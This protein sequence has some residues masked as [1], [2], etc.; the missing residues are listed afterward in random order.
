MLFRIAVS[1][2]SAYLSFVFFRGVVAGILFFRRQQS[3]PASNARFCKDPQFNFYRSSV[4]HTLAPSD[5]SVFCFCFSLNVSS[6][7][8]HG[9]SPSS[10][11][12]RPKRQYASGALIWADTAW[13]G[14]SAHHC[15]PFLLL[16]PMLDSS[17][18]S[19]RLCFSLV[20]V[21][22][23]ER[24]CRWLVD[25]EAPNSVAAKE[26]ERAIRNKRPMRKAQIG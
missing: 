15:L 14:R 21:S 23:S 26:R 2:F 18:C 22:R 24:R 11:A 16:P 10:P 7:E 13:S 19:S 25:K 4:C 8:D 6:C 9:C 5:C 1:C 12:L 3:E 17:G 20:G